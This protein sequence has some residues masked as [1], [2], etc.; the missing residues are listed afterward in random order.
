MQPNLLII[1]LAQAPWRSAKVLGVRHHIMAR[2]IVQHPSPWLPTAH[3]T[4][5][6]LTPHDN[7]NL[8]AGTL[9]HVWIKSL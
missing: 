4:G 3:V 8:K 7:G 9:R 6:A 5:H 2:D 1:S